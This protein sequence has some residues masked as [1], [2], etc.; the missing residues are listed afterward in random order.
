MDRKVKACYLGKGRVYLVLMSLFVVTFPVLNMSP[1][2]IEM[3]KWLF[4]SALKP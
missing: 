4:N 2:K 3:E 1:Q